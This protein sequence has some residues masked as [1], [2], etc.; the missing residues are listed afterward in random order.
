MRSDF[1]VSASGQ[2]MLNE[3]TTVAPNHRFILMPHIGLYDMHGTPIFDGDVVQRK[4]PCFK[5][6]GTKNGSVI[7]EIRVRS[8]RDGRRNGCNLVTA[9]HCEIIGHIWSS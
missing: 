2:I 8:I 9:N 4:R 7:D 3:E 1:S 5:A 6:N